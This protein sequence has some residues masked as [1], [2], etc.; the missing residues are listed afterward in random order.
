M[1]DDEHSDFREGLSSPVDQWYAVTPADGVDLDPVPR[2]LYIG[3]ATGNRT[4]VLTD[5][6]GNDE[7]FIVIS[8]QILPVRPRQVQATG[9]MGVTGII[10]IL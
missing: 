3:T 7:T 1:A 2:G 6:E 4:L 8:G 10:A 5:S 9:T